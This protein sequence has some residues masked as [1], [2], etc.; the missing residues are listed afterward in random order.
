[1]TQ[2]ASSSPTFHVPVP[3]RALRVGL[4]QLVA[5]AP[6]FGL[7]W[8]PLKLR[9]KLPRTIGCS[10]SAGDRP[11]AEGPS[12]MSRA[13][14]AE[15][16]KAAC[17]LSPGVPSA[18]PS[19]VPP[20]TATSP[21]K[22]CFA[23]YHHMA[24]CERTPPALHI[25]RTGLIWG[26]ICCEAFRYLCWRHRQSLPAKSQPRGRGRSSIRVTGVAPAGSPI[27]R[28]VSLQHLRPLP[29][30]LSARQPGPDV[31][32]TRWA[33]FSSPLGVNRV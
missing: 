5:L 25:S 20:V 2:E 28:V 11:G 22:R 23:S 26:C 8:H 10:S 13:A 30:H 16:L 33:G 6:L 21:A 3:C 7:I 15:S 1:M 14:T 9:A 4:S 17:W 19:P 32:Q 18:A 27:S 31:P 24:P 12:V 29:G